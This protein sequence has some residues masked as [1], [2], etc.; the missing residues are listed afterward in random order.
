MEF[1]TPHTPEE[2]GMAKRLNRTIIQMA[3]AML[4]WAEL[5]K[6]FWEAAKTANYLRNVLPLAN[7]QCLVHAHVPSASRA[8]L[9]RVS[10]QGIFVGYHSHH[11]FRIYNPNSRRIEQKTFALF[12]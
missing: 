12:S 7:N 3:R 6:T 10:F 8:K 11:Q 2:N 4:H 1:T 5:P 9:D